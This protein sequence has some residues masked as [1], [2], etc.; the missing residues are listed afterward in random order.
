M[1]FLYRIPLFHFNIE[2]PVVLEENRKKI[3]EAIKLSSTVFYRKLEGKAFAELDRNLRIKLRK[4]LLRGRFRPTPFGMFAGAGVGKWGEEINLH[5]PLQT[6]EIDRKTRITPSIHTE[7]AVNPLNS[8]YRLIPG[9]HKKLGY[10]H[11]L[12]FDHK[13]KHWKGCKLPVNSLFENLILHT[14]KQPIDFQGFQQLLNPKGIHIDSGQAKSLWERILETG[15]LTPEYRTESQFNGSDMVVQNH[16]EIPETTKKQ[17]QQFIDSAGALFAKEESNFVR[18]FKNWFTTH[19]DDRYLKLETLLSHSDFL[20]GQFLQHREPTENDIA[21]IL[22]GHQTQRSLDLKEFFP[23][24]E[25]DKGIYDLQILFRLDSLGNP[26]IENMVCNRPFVYTG[27]FN[28]HPAIELH[29]QEIKNRIYTD[30]QVIYAHL[31]LTESDSKQHIC[32]V[33]NI[34]AYEITP[35]VP[36]T[37]NQLG[38]DELYLGISTN[39]IQLFHKPSGKR[40]IPVV[41]HPLNGEQITHPILRLLWEAAHQERY[42]FKPYQGETLSNAP[43]CSQLNWGKICL[44]SRRWRLAAE[45]V[46]DISELPKKLDDLGIPQP[47]LAGHADRE[48]LLNLYHKDD[49]QILWQELKRSQTLT[50]SDPSWFPSAIFRSA[51][52]TAA[53]PQFVFQYSRPQPTS[54]STGEFNPI[55]EAQDNCLYFTLTLDDSDVPEV[56]ECLFQHLEKPEVSSK[57]PYWFF[58]IYGKNGAAEIRLRLLEIA[59]K[60]KSLLLASFSDLFSLEGLDWKTASYYP[61]N[62]KYGIKDLKISHRLF[63]MESKFLASK[64]HRILH[65]HDAPGDKENLIV[66]LWTLILSQSP[67]YPQ[68]FEELKGEVKSIPSHHVSSFKSAFNYVSKN[69]KEKF[70]ATAYLNNIRSHD[71]FYTVGNS[72]ILFLLNHLHMMVNRFFPQETQHH[73]ARI[74]YRLY[75]ELGKQIYSIPR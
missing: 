43:F 59:A 54:P 65:L 67:N 51:A 74:R 47:I 20:S 16:P 14:S 49:L 19:F 45:S 21:P 34:F 68:L 56:L 44:Q 73:E 52:G 11:A 22:L 46:S 39:Q 25:P 63:H 38:F 60:E 32:N 28:R 69:D 33:T 3:L 26:V 41:L 24:K 29:S 50:I 64:T 1:S 48:L 70:P 17:L 4:Y 6:V 61:E 35:F 40:V 9:V 62:S 31:A 8:N 15:F 36:Q 27:R 23:N 42:R 57:V 18:D 66:S 75:R 2:D 13:S 53:Y 10:Y 12:I 5:F 37:Q 72:G 55:T 58:L 7:S 30:N 71:Y